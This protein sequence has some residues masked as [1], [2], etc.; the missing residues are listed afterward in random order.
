MYVT[1]IYNYK[2]LAISVGKYSQE[3]LTNDATTLLAT[4]NN[5]N[6]DID[7][8]NIET[9][10]ILAIRLYDLGKKDDAVYWFYRA[11]LRGRVFINM[12]N[13]RKIGSIGSPAFETKQFFIAFNELAGTYINGYGG[14]DIDKMLQTIERVKGEAKNI[15]SYKNVYK[16]ISFIDDKNLE[17][18]ILEQQKGMEGLMDYMA[19]NKERI[20]K[21]RQEAGIEGKY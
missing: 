16:N 8:T 21:Q 6:K 1:P 9:L 11:Q 7:N 18:Q 10:Y 17:N 12:L 5:I 13:P 2:P 14:N 15:H 4:A 20:K 19:K 3:L